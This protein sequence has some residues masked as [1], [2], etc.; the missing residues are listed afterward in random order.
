ME[1][2]P[3]WQTYTVGR[4][5]ETTSLTSERRMKNPVGRLGHYRRAGRL[6]FLIILS[7]YHSSMML[8]WIY[9]NPWSYLICS[10]RASRRSAI[11]NI[12][13]G[14]LPPLNRDDHEIEGKSCLLCK[15]T[16]VDELLS[17]NCPCSHY[18]F[19]NLLLCLFIMDYHR[20]LIY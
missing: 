13:P 20:S 17:F 2:V 4:H 6:E 16:Y 12:L 10:S 11:E 19:Y 5:L 7:N 8:L 15:T 18:P 14:I 3:R 1:I 9:S